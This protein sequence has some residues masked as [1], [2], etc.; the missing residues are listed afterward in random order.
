MPWSNLALPATVRDAA[1]DAYAQ[2]VRHRVSGWTAQRVKA[3]GVR[4]IAAL[5]AYKVRGEYE[6]MIEQAFWDG[7]N[8]APP[9]ARI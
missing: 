3:E 8:S 5:A 7:F 9:G 2:G 1:Y 6:E 4:N